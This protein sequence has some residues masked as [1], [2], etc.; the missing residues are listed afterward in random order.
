MNITNLI[1]NKSEFETFNNGCYEEV[2]K[3]IEACGHFQA[4]I[5]TTMST[6]FVVAFIFLA[7]LVLYQM[8]VNNNNP[9]YSTTEF[10]K[11]WIH[12][13]IDYII[14]ILVVSLLVMWFV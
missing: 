5:I 2:N 13:R 10:Y 7:L 6:R 3:C 1:L 12:R 14:I 11:R 8:Y 4:K 9:K